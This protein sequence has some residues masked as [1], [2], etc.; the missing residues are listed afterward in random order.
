M[1]GEL[2]LNVHGIFT[3]RQVKLLSAVGIERGCVNKWR[4]MN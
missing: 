1:N 2:L 3:A 4:R